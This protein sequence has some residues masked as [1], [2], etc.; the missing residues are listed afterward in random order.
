M[1]TLVD[2]SAVLVDES[3][4]DRKYTASFPWKLWG[5]FQ[6]FTASLLCLFLLSYITVLLGAL[7]LGVVLADRN[8]DLNEAWDGYALEV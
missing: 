6:A 1:E 8:E 7:V 3:D 4:L 2:E 5:I